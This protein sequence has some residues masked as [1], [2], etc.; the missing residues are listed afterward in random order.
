MFLLPIRKMR[1]LKF[2]V[3]Q[4][5]RLLC[6]G[7][8][9]RA[10]VALAPVLDGVHSGGQLPVFHYAQDAEDIALCE[11]LPP[12]GYYVDIG[13]HH[14]ERFSVTKLL[15]DRGWSGINIDVTAEMVLGGDF[16]V[17]RPRDTNIYG[18]VGQASEVKF[19]R[20]KEPAL[21]TTNRERAQILID[22]GYE[23]KSIDTLQSLPLQHHLEA[24]GVNGRPID[25]LNVDV[26]G[27]DFEVVRGIN[28]EAQRV[29]AVL[30]EIGK[31]AWAVAADDIS[32]FLAA[33]G[34]CP[35]LVFLRSV[36]YLPK[37]SSSYSYFR[38]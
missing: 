2:A 15:Y 34:F 6:S 4:L 10:L 7:K 21:S 14:P 16:S 23:C 19:Y 27:A 24:L 25:F 12:Q 36:L 8:Q 3:R 9:W 38:A 17:R 18:L 33:K 5:L 28:W 13:A 22:A 11:I 32:Q 35:V 37:G 20:F 30:V 26:E 29:G 1:R 31:P